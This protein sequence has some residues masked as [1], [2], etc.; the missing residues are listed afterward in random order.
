MIPKFHNPH[1]LLEQT[2]NVSRKE[3]FSEDAES[4]YTEDRHL[5]LTLNHLVQSIVELPESLEAETDRE[6]R[7]KKKR[8][9]KHVG[10]RSNEDFGELGRG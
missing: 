4:E 1:L 6:Q 10:D 7:P 3:I 2:E 5:V 9:V 8:K